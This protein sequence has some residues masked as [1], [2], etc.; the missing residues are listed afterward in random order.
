MLGSGSSS[1]S[2]ELKGK[3]L[4]GI[5]LDPG[6]N[7]NFFPFGRSSNPFGR[8]FDLFVRGFEASLRNIDPPLRD[9]LFSLSYI[10]YLLMRKS[11][12]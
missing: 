9:F 1:S 6:L 8:L 4:S 5:F 12:M 3:N 7:V 10:R 2:G 11:G